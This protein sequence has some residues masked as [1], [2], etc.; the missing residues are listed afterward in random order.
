MME[1][2]D[3][4][5]KRKIVCLLTGAVLFL[6]GCKAI[7]TEN[8]TVTENR[9]TKEATAEEPA[10]DEAENEPVDYHSPDMETVALL[11]LFGLS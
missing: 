3:E 11:T 4:K 9:D 8:A 2:G 6:S 5:M 10:Q 1:K 7:T